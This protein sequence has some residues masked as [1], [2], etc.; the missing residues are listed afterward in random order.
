VLGSGRVTF[1]LTDPVPSSAGV[2]VFTTGFGV[3]VTFTTGFGVGVTFTTGFGVGVTFTTGFDVG[4]TLGVWLTAGFVA[5]LWW[6]GV[7]TGRECVDVWWVERACFAAAVRFGVAD[8]V[9]DSPG[10]AADGDGVVVGDDASGTTVWTFVPLGRSLLEN[11]PAAAADAT[12]STSTATAHAPRRAQTPSTRPA[13]R[14]REP[15][16]GSAYAA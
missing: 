4:V 14:P 16:G 2:G 6:V 13:K 1:W 10:V 5:V 7:A 12:R 11:S 15:C 9:A 3:G 8:A